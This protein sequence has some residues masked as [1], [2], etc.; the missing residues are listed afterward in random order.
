M[1]ILLIKYPKHANTTWLWQEK[2][3]LMWNRNY[4]TYIESTVY[5]V[6]GELSLHFWLIYL[7]KSWTHGNIRK[8]FAAMT[9]IESQDDQTT[10]W[11]LKFILVSQ[12]NHSNCWWRPCNKVIALWWLCQT[13][14]FIWALDLESYRTNLL[15]HYNLTVFIGS[16]P[17]QMQVLFSTILSYLHTQSQTRIPFKFLV[18]F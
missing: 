18:Y 2:R 17:L 6:F 9:R 3:C 13:V 14:Q 8:S 11:A 10:V 4:E 15:T 12:I 1:I 5:C 7:H 16:L